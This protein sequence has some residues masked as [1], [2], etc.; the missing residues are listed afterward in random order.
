MKK[1]LKKIIPFVLLVGTTTMSG[2]S[3]YS[4]KADKKENF[5]G[6]YELDIYQ[7]KRE[8]ADE[9]PYDRKAEEG[10][11]AYFTLDI[12]G[13][14][15]Y[16]YKSNT[17]EA[18]VKPVYSHYVPDEEEEGLFEAITLGANLKKH[19]AWD[20]FVGCL[21]EPTMG[22]RRQEVKT[23]NGI[24]KKKEMV[25]TLSYTIPWHVYTIYNPDKIQ[26]YQYVSYKKISDSTDYQQIN[27]KL[28]TNFVPNKPMEM[29]GTKGFYVYSYTLKESVDQESFVKPYEYVILDTDSYSNGKFTMYYSETANPGRKSTQVNTAI[30]TPGSSYSVEALGRTF[31]G[32][33]S[34][35][36][37]Y[38]CVTY[39]NTDMSA[40]TDEDNYSYEQFAPYYGEAT[41]LD[42]LIAE[43]TTPQA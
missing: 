33:I 43:L 7:A 3:M 23:G 18:W 6:F 9:E 15:Y 4:S 39:L 34:D 42:E 40:Y 5:V 12:D 25:C 19:W 2:C 28:G 36:N 37:D 17:Q 8:A 30:V 35:A 16:G 20:K 10:I 21:D 27:Q 41:T 31:T 11:S 26:K 32:G 29:G 1:A 14:G 13:Y 38:Q 22:F 24:F